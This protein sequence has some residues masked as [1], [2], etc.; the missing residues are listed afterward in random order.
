LLKPETVFV[1]VGWANNEIGTIQPL[2]K[3]GR[4]PRARENV[5]PYGLGI[6]FKTAKAFGLAVPGTLIA[7]ADEVIE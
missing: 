7:F 3:I 6:N 4:Y 2:S 5:V 1:S